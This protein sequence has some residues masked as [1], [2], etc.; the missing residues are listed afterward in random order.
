MFQEEDFWP[1]EKETNGEVE[2]LGNYVEI[3]E[4]TEMMANAEQEPVTPLQST[5]VQASSSSQPC[6]QQNMSVPTSDGATEM[7]GA[8]LQ[9]VLNQGGSGRWMIFT[10]ALKLSI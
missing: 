1:W 5:S 4:S 6:S 3:N 10:I 7:T 2:F 9:P 8:S